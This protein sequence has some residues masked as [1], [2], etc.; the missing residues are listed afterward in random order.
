M[1][2]AFSE[3]LIYTS[4]LSVHLESLLTKLQTF[5]YKP[6]VIRPVWELYINLTEREKEVLTKRIEKKKS[7][8]ESASE[9]GITPQGVVTF[10][11]SIKDKVREAMLDYPVPT[12]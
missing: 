7:L 5:T 4:C 3:T 6:F 9:M 12:D 8:T 10:M 11:R 2:L 1:N